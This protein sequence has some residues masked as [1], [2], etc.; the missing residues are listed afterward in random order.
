MLGLW[1]KFKASA[2]L[3]AWVAPHVRQ[4]QK[5]PER[6]PEPVSLQEVLEEAVAAAQPASPDRVRLQLQLAETQRKQAEGDSGKLDEAEALIRAAIEIAASTSDS[7]G[8]V[9]CLDALAQVYHDRGDFPHMQ[10][11]LEEG[12]RIEASLP[13]PDQQRMAR[14]VH[15]LAISHSLQGEDAAELLAKALDLHEKAFGKDHVETGNVLTDLGV[16]HRSQGRYEEAHAC[17]ERALKIH[18]QKIDY[19]SP[20]AL[21]D[22][23]ILSCSLAESGDVPAAV[24]HYDRALELLD[25]VVGADQDRLAEL[26]FMVAGLYVEWEHY[27]GAREL[28]A[29]CLGTFRRKK[30]PRLAVAHELAAH[31]EELS[32][33]Y[34]SAIAELE[35]AGKIWRTCVPEKAEELANNLEYRA[36]LLDQL[37]RK[38]SASWLREKAMLARAGEFT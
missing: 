26:Q 14:R 7:V 11:L 20:E 15:G 9:Q 22:V 8:Y 4:W 27:G 23:H 13:H 19:T 34:L 36:N 38:D 17:L 10:S 31:I 3:V 30:G 2:S 18:G 1:L 29:M 16:L 25:R 12:I 5:E 28:L 37:K 6:Q 35:R 32:G 21:R 24:D 33:R